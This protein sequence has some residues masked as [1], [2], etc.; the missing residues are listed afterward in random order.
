VNAQP[1]LDRPPVS[2]L[3]RETS[4][5]AGT[6]VEQAWQTR[7]RRQWVLMGVGVVLAIVAIAWAATSFKE[8]PAPVAAGTAPANDSLPLVSVL[9]PT[10]ASVTS[11]VNFTGAIHARHDMPISVE[12]EGG[13]ITAL[14][15]EAGDSVRRGQLMARIDQSVTLPQVNRL[16]ASLEEARA[17]AALSLA[18][19]G[20]AQGV[21]AAG[22]LSKEEIERR[23][24]ASVTDEARVKVAA[25]QLA[26][27]QA[28]L[29]RTE[30]RAPSDGIVLT[31]TAEVGQTA[32]PASEPL[33][34]LARQGEVEM[35]GQVSEQDMPK[36]RVGQAATAWL[37][38]V[39]DAFQ[40][41]VRLLGAVIDPETRL[42]EIR[43]SLPSDPRL[44]PGAF[45][46][47]RVVI[48]ETHS[49][50]LPQTAV[51]SDARSTYVYIVNAEG[52]VERR[53]VVVGDTSLRGI[54][55]TSGLT[56]KERVVSTAGGFL[57]EGEQVNVAG[58]KTD[59]ETATAP[60]S[61]TQP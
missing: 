49:P 5:F 10:A 52:R 16:A 9:T 57:R 7:R 60:K 42:G 12:G 41:E 26:E 32:S 28:R 1:D 36:L 50:V 33:F 54:V 35:R 48:G 46:R 2:P 38:G 43:I 25:A 39:A 55:V 53:N 4:H 61:A 51:M 13:R 34:R 27:A 8:T 59:V 22:A 45:A 30:I 31:R 20:R 17:Q 18:E 19:Y 21:E 58:A 6:P 14:F 11:T 47:G 24:A 44:R 29:E 23:R 15:V 40:G 37:T 3:T 56:G